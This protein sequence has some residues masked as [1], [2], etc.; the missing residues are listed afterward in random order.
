MAGLRQF[1]REMWEGATHP[2]LATHIVLSQWLIGH[3][4]RHRGGG[5]PKVQTAS[6]G[7]RR[8]PRKS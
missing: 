1:V 6:G 7:N 2:R 8:G 5:G 3:V 4:H